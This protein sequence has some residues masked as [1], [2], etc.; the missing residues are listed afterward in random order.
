MIQLSLDSLV[1]TL[2]AVAESSRLR[3]LNLLKRG[4]L[5][6]TDITAVLGQSQPRVSRHLKLL[7]D[8]GLIARYQE[9]SWAFFRID[10]SSTAGLLGSE[11]VDRL[12]MQ[13]VFM[14]RDLERLGQVKQDRQARAIE[15]FTKNAQEWDQIRSLH[16]PDA[17]VEAMLVKIVGQTQFQSMLDLGTGTGRLLELF[18]PLYKR[19]VGIDMSRDMLAVAR[20]N[21]E[22]SGISHVQVRQGD[23]LN[24]PVEREAFDLVTIHQVLHFLDEPLSAIREASRALRAGGRLIIVDFASHDLETLR[25]KHAH[26]RLGFADKQMNAWLKECG[27]KP[28]KPFEVPAIGSG[29]LTVKVWPA[30]DPR[31]AND[32]SVNTTPRML[33]NTQ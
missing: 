30:V 27:L 33:E 3:I 6:V 21:L 20:A 17:A 22:K 29:Q 4:D 31:A 23:I 11:L 9:G 10:D 8:A 14:R 15:Y 18:A 25:E 12:D 5:T 28:Q 7:H 13:N 1:D 26:L 32:V 19:G 24:P 16:A 2:K